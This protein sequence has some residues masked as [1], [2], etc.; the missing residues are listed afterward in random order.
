M[1]EDVILVTGA[2]GFIGSH[3]CE[4]LVGRGKTVV[5][6][7]N[8][9]PAY[10]PALK[11]ANLAALLDEPR[12][13]FIEG[14]I[15]EEDALTRA[16]SKNPRAVVHLAAKGGVRASIT[17][18]ESYY[19]C[20]VRGTLR[21]LEAARNCEVEHF[22]FGSSSSVYGATNTVPF[23]EDQPTD[24]PMSPYAA[25]KCAAEGLCHTWHHL[26]GLNVICLRFFTVYGPRQRPDLAIRRF[27]E[28]LRQGK[29]IPR[30]G[31]G[32]S[33]RD[34]TYIADIVR[35]IVAALELDASFE[36][37][38][39]GNSSPVTLAELI[40]LVGRACGVTPVIEEL[41]GQPGDM[42]HTFAD[43]SKAER[44]LGWRPEWSM[45]DG[46]REFVKWYDATFS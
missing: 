7:D 23:S 22:I 26:Y 46:L 10:E 24:R 41:P 31:D 11:R 9:D 25:S 36:V 17:D 1:P 37:I 19:D 6:L 35:G 15:R 3:L 28:L 13:E 2:A 42:P 38:N 4:A 39:L 14:D 45:A 18:P 40:E 34:Y 30:F 32:T 29:P 16:S 21:V 12:F 27:V 33:S 44:L 5:G 8:F 43:I 20:N